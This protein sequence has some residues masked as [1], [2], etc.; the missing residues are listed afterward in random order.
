MMTSIRR[1]TT[2]LLLVA[3]LGLGGQAAA[4]A[5]SP[6]A[7][8]VTD[9]IQAFYLSLEDFQSRF[10]QI[11]TDV[12]ADEEKRFSGKVFFKKPGKMR[13]DYLTQK[14]NK[15][16]LQK[17]L[18]SNGAEFTIYEAE[19]DQYFRQCLKDSQL[20]TAL[21][22]L[23][24]TGDLKADFDIKLLPTAPEGSLRLELT[25]KKSAGQYKRLEFVVDAKDYSVRE[26]VVYDPYGNTNRVRFEAP[27]LNKQLPDAGFDFSPP[28]GTRALGGEKELNCQ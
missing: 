8:Q 21:R 6:T 17:V 18:V 9:K 3:T 4:Q 1:A 14:D 15:P 19:Y 28:V 22:F 25:P 10:T 11:Y 13:W 12:A 2:S 7:A 27:V 23:M 26:T 20:P 5:P 16:A 24:G